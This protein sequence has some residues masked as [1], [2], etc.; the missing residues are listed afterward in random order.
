MPN[1]NSYL[2]AI[3]VFYDKK[4]I[5]IQR[6]FR[7]K[8]GDLRSLYAS[9]EEFFNSVLDS[10]LIPIYNKSGNELSIHLFN[11]KIL[12][13]K[14]A[15]NLTNKY[16]DNLGEYSDLN[17]DNLVT[18]FKGIIRLEASNRENKNI[19]LRNNVIHHLAIKLNVTEEDIMLEVTKELDY[20]VLEIFLEEKSHNLV[21][22]YGGYIEED[23]APFFKGSL[24][25]EII[26]RENGTLTAENSNLNYLSLK[27]GV[28][29]ETL[30]LDITKELDSSTL[31]NKLSASL[32]IQDDD[33]NFP[34]L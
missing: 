28:S 1:R 26:N 2:N 5:S 17:K 15:R 21:A 29:K 13:E 20:D 18:V 27:L 14:K 31:S 4:E 6:S 16:I 12:L 23:I 22:K 33:T 34:F 11:E 30:M 24:K 9:R 10:N 3:E 8:E 32:I 7:G 19:Q 25:T